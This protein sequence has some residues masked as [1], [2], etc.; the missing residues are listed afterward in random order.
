MKSDFDAAKKSEKS[1]LE[2][3][4][5]LA[6]GCVCERRTII[7]TII[8]NIVKEHGSLSS[9]NSPRYLGTAKEGER[10]FL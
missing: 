5:A 8:E 4:A 2:R 9:E 7:Q 10:K 3:G 1:P 6:V